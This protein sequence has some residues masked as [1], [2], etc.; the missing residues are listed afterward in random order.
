M[1]TLA[2]EQLRLPTAAELP[3]SDDTPV[4]NELQNDTPNIL[5]EILR[6]IWR[7]RSD[8]YWGVDM[9]VY[10][11]PDLE[12]PENSKA[13]VPDGFLALG[14]AQRRPDKDGRSSYPLW[15]EK[16]PILVLEVVS[17]TYNGEYDDKVTKYQDLGVLYYVIYNPFSGKRPYK[18]RQ[19][20][21]VYKLVDG[22]YELMPLAILPDGGRMVWLNEIGLGIGYEQGMRGDWERDWLYW[23]DRSGV[24]YPTDSERAAQEKLAKEQ[25]EL[26]KQQ[27]E[28]IAEQERQEK[29][30]ERLAKQQAEAIATQER[31]E[32]LQ[33]R[34]AKQEAEA[35]A[36]QANLAKQEAEAIAQ[37]ERQEKERL[38]AYLRSLGINPNEI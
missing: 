35:I 13:I 30:Q 34:I 19:F 21:D 14:V 23:Y 28:A 1:T 2:S 33:E 16:V 25:A 31:Q 5:L 10:Y 36:I 3:D 18:K 17:K 24:K 29:L 27:A 32:K 4:D 12:Q 6:W 7:D 20:M 37:Q 9:G 22:K 8:W 38:A 15:Q 26:A 11:E